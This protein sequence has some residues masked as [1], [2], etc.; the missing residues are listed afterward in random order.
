MDE[1]AKN[2]VAFMYGKIQSIEASVNR[3]NIQNFARVAHAPSSLPASADRSIDAA[4]DTIAQPAQRDHS[5]R[6]SRQ[7]SVRRVFLFM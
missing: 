4:L 5:V 2:T 6:G 1:C 3:D 7:E